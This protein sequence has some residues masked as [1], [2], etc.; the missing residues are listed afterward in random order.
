MTRKTILIIAVLIVFF[1]GVVVLKHDREGAGIREKITFAVAK[2]YL[3]APIYVA[4]DKGFFAREGVDVTLQPHLS[5]RDALASVINGQ[6]QFAS[7][8]ETPVMFAGL[9]GEK[10]FIIAS[11]GDSNNHLKIV[12]RKDRG[13]TGPQ[14]LRGKT[15]GVL[16][17]AAP[18]YFLDVFLTYNGLKK[19]NIHIVDTKAEETTDAIAEGKID[20]AVTW[21]PLLT[22]QLKTLRDNATLLTNDRIYN[23]QWTI[24]AGQAFVK[25]HRD[26]V[27][28]L[29]R[30]LIKA[31]EYIASNP[32][33]AKAITARHVSEE[34]VSFSDY[35]FDVRLGQSLLLNLETQ[36]RW[37]IRYRLTDK[38]DVPNFLP[39]MFTEGLEAIDPEA[40]TVIHK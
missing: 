10:I 15:V 9:K 16:R 25:V 19:D 12:C 33:D 24:V 13:I 30:A 29:L 28:K 35:I 26:T 14:D 27:R 11:I 31:N 22:A 20:A 4:H 38:K 34:S 39:M 3:S 23:L 18:E 40:V 21:E 32:G 8:A 6:A 5:G 36:A 37:A 2:M 7:S 1:G 17:G